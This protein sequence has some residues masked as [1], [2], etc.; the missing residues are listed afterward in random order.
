[1]EYYQET[2]DQTV[3]GK[4]V[5]HYLPLVRFH[6]SKLAAGLPVH[7]SREDLM[8]SGILGLLEALQR[9]D[10]KRGIKFET[11]ASQRIRGAMLDELR[12]LCWLP[13]SLVRQMRSMDRT[14]Q[15][16]ASSLG[17]EPSD[18]EL[19]AEMGITLSE[20]QKTVKQAHKSTLISL[21][22]KLS[23]PVPCS[24][25]EG[26]TL[27][28]LLAE[29]EKEIL[30]N[31]IESLD[32]RYRVILALYYQEKLKLKE[33]GVVLGISESRVCQ[34]HTRAVDKLRAIMLD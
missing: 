30:A 22:E 11:Y 20:L 8:Q 23:V 12:R 33:I 27:D 1:M 10:S 9:Y 14:T 31:A 24:N 15:S 29:E 34:L 18:E 26:G 3:Y 32:E 28:R 2:K 25:A 4:L 5:S 13:R 21:D 16:L 19:A 6:T 17:R 7:V